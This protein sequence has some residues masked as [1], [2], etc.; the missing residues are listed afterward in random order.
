MHVRQFLTRLPLWDMSFTCFM[1]NIIRIPI[2]FGTFRQAFT[3]PTFRAIDVFYYRIEYRCR[4]KA[5]IMPPRSWL[6]AKP[7]MVWEFNTVP[8]YGRWWVKRTRPWLAYC[9]SS[10]VWRLS[11]SGR[12][13]IARDRRYVQEKLGFRHVMTVPNGTDPDLSPRC[14]TR[15]AHCAEAQR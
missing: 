7:L 8:E 5:M 12:L 11:R 15:A 2:P 4:P 14:S 10:T 6:S 13:R 1:A 9:R 3:A